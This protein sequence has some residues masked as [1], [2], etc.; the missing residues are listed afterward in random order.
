MARPQTDIDAGRAHLLDM[1]EELI[2]KRG[3]ASVTLAELANAAGMSSGNIYRFFE[4][5][6][7]L[8]EAV[9]ERWFAPKIR[10][11]EEVVESDLPIRDKLYAFFARRFALMQEN[12]NADPALFQS[13]CELGHEHFEMVR[14]YIDLGDHYLAILV[15]E[16]M[17]AGHFKGLSIDASVS[18]INLM[19]HPFCDPEV[20]SMLIHSVTEAKLRIVID[21]ILG[22][23][24]GEALAHSSGRIAAAA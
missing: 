2:R 6:E 16:A 1:V 20:M 5:K 7:A 4:S 12:W 17:E 21:A 15:A 13:Y 11:M 18:L 22:G 24:S 10:I 19:V 3:A 14:G 8:Y 9:A 23:L